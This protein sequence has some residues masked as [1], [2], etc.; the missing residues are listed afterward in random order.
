[1]VPA[2]PACLRLYRALNS[3]LPLIPWGHEAWWLPHV[4]H[5]SESGIEVCIL[6]IHLVHLPVIVCSK[7]Q[8]HTVG[9]EFCHRCKGC[10]IIDAS[11]LCEPLCYQ[12]GFVAG[13]FPACVTFELV[14]PPAPNDVDAQWCVNSSHVCLA[15]SLL[16]SLTMVS[17]QCGQCGLPRASASFLGSVPARM[18]AAMACRGICM[19]S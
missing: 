16:T 3:H 13:D 15:V 19:S 10:I 17:C 9:G 1:M 14:S 7:G 5:L 2:L 8:H 6:N 4:N 18:L 12:A 11:G